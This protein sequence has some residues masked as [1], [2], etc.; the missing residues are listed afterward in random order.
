MLAVFPSDSG[1]ALV[2]AISSASWALV[3]GGRGSALRVSVRETTAATACLIP[4]WTNELPSVKKVRSGSRS[5]WSRRSGLADLPHKK[6]S[7]SSQE[8]GAPLVERSDAGFR[9]EHTRR[10]TSGHSNNWA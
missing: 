10:L 2:R 8:C 5:G 3:E 9:A 4:S 7:T 1:N 6:A